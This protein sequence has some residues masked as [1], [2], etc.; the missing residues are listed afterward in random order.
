VQ[1]VDKKKARLNCINHLL[2]QVPYKPVEREHI[3]LPPRV[4]HE[5]YRRSPITPHLLVPEVY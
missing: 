1:A 5:G 2:A 3:S 4:H